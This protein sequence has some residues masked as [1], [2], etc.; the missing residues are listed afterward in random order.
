MKNRTKAAA[1]LASVV[2]A[3]SPVVALAD[4][5]AQWNFNNSTA[6]ST[7]DSHFSGTPTVSLLGGV[8]GTLASGSGSTDTSPTNNAYNLT[9]FP[10][11]STASETAGA[12]YD[13]NTTNYTISSFGFDLRTSNTSSRNY[14]LQYS[15]DGSTWQE[16]QLSPRPSPTG[17]TT[18]TPSISAASPPPAT[19]L[20]SKFASS[21]FSAPPDSRMGREPMDANV[22]YQLAQNSPDQVVPW[23][24]VLGGLT[25]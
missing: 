9:T 4:I 23:P 20:I 18:E 22:A 15:T 5:L 10:A 13:F 24:P 8:T 14:E 25:W 2:A 1:I 7:V 3:A 11:Q 16:A 21:R 17:S 12:E 19:T 6:P